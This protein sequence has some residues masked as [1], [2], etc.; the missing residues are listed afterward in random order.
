[1]VAFED[2]ADR[3]KKV[4]TV[5]NK[6]LQLF[7]K[8]EIHASWAVVGLLGHSSLEDLIAKNKSAQISYSHKNFSVFPITYDNYKDIPFEILTGLNEVKRILKTPH[9]E[10]SSHTFAHYYTLEEGQTETEFKA[11]LASM[12]AFGNELGHTF[13]S[14]IFPRNQINPSYLKILNESKYV[15]FRGNQDNK[16]WANSSFLNET[17]TQ[18]VRRVLDAYFS[19]SKTKVYKIADLSSVSGLVNIPASRFL[20]PNRGKSLWE[21][22]KLKRVKE[23]MT[24][25]AINGTIYHLWWHPH[26]FTFE[27]EMSLIQLEE[28]LKHYQNLNKAYEFISLNMG[29][30]ADH[31]RK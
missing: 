6:M 10:L 15:A 3:F 4:E 8:Y 14:I 29:E 19:I 21:K 12:T 28:I 16:D 26:N 9:Q 17:K 18:K 2:V 13:R 20:R 31:V 30:I 25:A 24:E 5:V 22:R 7:E 23:E 27:P 1:M 11:D